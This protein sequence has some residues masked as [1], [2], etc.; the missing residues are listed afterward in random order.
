M[1]LEKIAD[2]VTSVMEYDEENVLIGRD[3]IN[4]KDFERNIIVVDFL[5][6]PQSMSNERKYDYDLEEETFCTIFNGSFTV[7]FYGDNSYINVN[8]FI[9]LSNSQRSKDYQKTNEITV[10]K[11]KGF[12]DLKQ[13]VGNRY[14]E[15][16]E[17]EILVQYSESLTIDT[18]RIESIP[19]NQIDENGNSNDYVVE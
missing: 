18:Y 14:F 11:S 1:I 6:R 17:V 13:V 4:L 16:Y 9:N 12:N 15:R 5:G 10:F 19:V 3:N 8:K 7:E 2:Y